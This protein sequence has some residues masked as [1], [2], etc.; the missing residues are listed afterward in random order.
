MSDAEEE[1]EQGGALEVLSL[2]YLLY[3]YNSTCF[4]QKYLLYWYKS[5][6]TDA[7]FAALQAGLYDGLDRLGIK[8]KNKSNADD[9]SSR[10]ERVDESRDQVSVF[11]LLY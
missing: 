11:V 4:I 8:I 1:V 9:G 5:T 6:H 3:W 10:G 7:L 2:L